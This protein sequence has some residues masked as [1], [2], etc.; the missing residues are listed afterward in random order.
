V[1]A[2]SPPTADSAYGRLR[3]EINCLTGVSYKR[4]FSQVG[5][6]SAGSARAAGHVA[7]GCRA[8]VRP[9]NFAGLLFGSGAFY[10]KFDVVLRRC[11]LAPLALSCRSRPAAGRSPPSWGRSSAHA[12]GPR[13]R[14]TRRRTARTCHSLCS[15]S[16]P[17]LLRARRRAALALVRVLMLHRCPLF[18]P[19]YLSREEQCRL[20]PDLH[21]GVILLQSELHS[22]HSRRCT[23]AA[24]AATAP[25]RRC[26]AQ[27]SREATPGEVVS[28][29][30]RHF[31]AFSPI[32]SQNG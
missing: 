30:R 9:H 7:L 31:G 26:V 13:N 2:W 28:Y 14:R 29:T 10:G 5:V 21:R 32:P 3:S 19:P 18:S 16:P 8:E 27:A 15:S 22:Q 25:R 17:T 24:H 20:I 12:G 23:H 1:R 6:G 11:Q 4:S